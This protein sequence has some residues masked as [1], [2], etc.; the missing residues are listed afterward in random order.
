MGI[1]GLCSVVVG[2]VL[3]YTSFSHAG[4]R[5]ITAAGTFVKRKHTLRSG[6]ATAVYGVGRATYTLYDR[7]SHGEN[8]KPLN[9]KESFFNWL[10]IVGAGASGASTRNIWVRL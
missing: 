10:S 1:G 4:E 2:N 8:I 7:A 3:C 6:I 5:L 9:N